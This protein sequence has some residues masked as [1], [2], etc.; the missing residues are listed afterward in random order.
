MTE[1]IGEFDASEVIGNGI[2]ITFMDTE[3]K[4]LTGFSIGF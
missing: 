1:D 2:A 4:V 3:A